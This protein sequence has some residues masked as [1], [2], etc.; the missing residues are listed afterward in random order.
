MRLTQ[1]RVR[2]ARVRSVFFN[3]T[4]TTTPKMLH[5]LWQVQPRTSPSGSRSVLRSA[6]Q[7]APGA[8][9][10]P[11][12]VSSVILGVQFLDFKN[13]P[14]IPMGVGFDLSCLGGAQ[15]LMG[16]VVHLPF[17]PSCPRDLWEMERER[18]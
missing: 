11:L 3:S 7:V 4:G 8:F 6:F 12:R 16:I 2:F 13:C 18:V 14:Q 9:I 17:P 10:F 1:R 5:I 15:L